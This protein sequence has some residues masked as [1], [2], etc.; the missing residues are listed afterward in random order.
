MASEQDNYP[1]CVDLTKPLRTRDGREVRIYAT[2]GTGCQPIHGAIKGG[3][4]W[5]AYQ[6]E[7]S[8]SA[9]FAYEK[10]LHRWDLVNA[11]A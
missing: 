2:D 4:G 6:W 1:D 10:R 3:W 7:P 9:C 8:G 11:A 5:R